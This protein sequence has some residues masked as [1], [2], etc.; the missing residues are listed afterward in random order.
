MARRVQKSTGKKIAVFKVKGGD[1]KIPFPVPSGGRILIVGWQMKIGNKNVQSLVF[2]FP[3]GQIHHDYT[4]RDD[5]D[6]LEV[7][8]PAV[9]DATAATTTT[10]AIISSTTVTGPESEPRAGIPDDIM[11]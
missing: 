7:Q 11:Q 8:M 4:W 6:H 2:L 9:A 1:I 5:A 3:N 10:D